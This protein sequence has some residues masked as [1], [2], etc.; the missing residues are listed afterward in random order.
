MHF[1]AE[2]KVCLHRGMRRRLSVAE[3]VMKETLDSH[4]LSSLLGDGVLFTFSESK[5]DK[6][7]FGQ[8]KIIFV[9]KSNINSLNCRNKEVNSGG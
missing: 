1:P 8:L 9:S 6:I 7:L 3:M 2:I 5:W 4:S